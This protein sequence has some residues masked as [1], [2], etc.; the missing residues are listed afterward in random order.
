MT[1]YNKLNGVFCGENEDAHRR[2]PASALGLQGLRGVGLVPR[3][4]LDGAQALRAGLDIEMPAPFR[5]SAEK[6]TAEL[7]RG[8]FSEERH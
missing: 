5:R 7:E 2:H 8:E 6:L 4:A 1:A 3:H